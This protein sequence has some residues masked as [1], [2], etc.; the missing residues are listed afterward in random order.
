MTRRSWIGLGGLSAL[1]AAGWYAFPQLGRR[2]QALYW[3]ATMG[4]GEGDLQPGDEA[5][6]FELQYRESPQTVKLS[7]FRGDRPVALVF[8]S[9]T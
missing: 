8:G 2:A 4:R 7:A 6:D 1:A 5:P 3:S 9:Y